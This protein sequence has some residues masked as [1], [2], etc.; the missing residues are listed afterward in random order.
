MTAPPSHHAGAFAAMPIPAT[1]IDAHGV[2]VDVNDAFLDLARRHNIPL[3]REDRIGRP[4][5]E[6]AGEDDPQLGRQAILDFLADGDAERWR[7]VE[8]DSTRR[9][10]LHDMQLL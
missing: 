3:R 4:I 6:F 2:I 8:Q 10:G 9:E 7:R 1:L 5:W